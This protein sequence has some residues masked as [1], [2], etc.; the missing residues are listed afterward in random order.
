MRGSREITFGGTFHIS[1]SPWIFS[2]HWICAHYFLPNIG[3]GGYFT[4]TKIED[5]D[6]SYA[7]GGI[8]KMNLP[9][10]LQSEKMLPFVG[11]GIG[12]AKVSDEKKMQISGCGGV[13]FFVTDTWA[14][15][16]MYRGSKIMEEGF[17]FQ[18]DILFGITH[19]IH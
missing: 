1:P 2:G 15:Y 4:F 11:A 10:L 8:A 18:S 12:I 17:D 6:A 9:M 19:S 16:V 13:D 7:L 14:V 5:F 3:I